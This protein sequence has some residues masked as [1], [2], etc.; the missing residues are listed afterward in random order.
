MK[1]KKHDTQWMV[2]CCTYGQQ[3]S[4]FWRTHLGMIQLPIIKATTVHIP[5]DHR[6]NSVGTGQQEAI[7]GLVFGIS[8][9][10]SVN[11]MA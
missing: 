3:L 11:T 4:F 5:G 1:T 9:L 6:V 8:V 10:W 7:L 2:Q